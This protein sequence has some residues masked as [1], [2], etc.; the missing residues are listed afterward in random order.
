[1]VSFFLSCFLS[2]YICWFPFLCHSLSLSIY[3]YMCVCVCVSVLV[4][5]YQPT[6]V[7]FC[8]SIYLSKFLSAYLHLFLSF[9]LSFSLSF[10][11]FIYLYIYASK[12]AVCLFTW[13]YFINLIIPSFIY[14]NTFNQLFSF[15]LLSNCF[16]SLEFFIP[17]LRVVFSWNLL[18]S[19][20]LF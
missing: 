4:G 9:L 19:P 16:I 20:K 14:P 6:S 11:L 8:L 13:L 1:M 18:R 3:I 15:V 17:K 12:L 5:F 2:I 7:L 10:F